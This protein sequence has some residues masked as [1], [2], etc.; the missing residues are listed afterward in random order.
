MIQA[1]P[2]TLAPLIVSVADRGGGAAIAARRLH[3]A[4]GEIGIQSRMAVR[5]HVP[6]D[7][8]V[9]PLLDGPGRARGLV[10]RRVARAVDH[11]ALSTPQTWSDG[12]LGT[13]SATHIDRL[14]PGV[15]NLH[16]VNDAMLSV[17][18]IG[19]VRAPIV[20][21]L[22]D[23]WAFT[24]GC[25]Y[26][27]ECGRYTQSCGHCP[28]LRAPGV[29]DLSAFN[30]A[31]KRRL[32]DCAR[33]TVVTPSRWMAGVAR[34]SALLGAAEVVAIPNPLN[35]TQFSPIERAAARAAL[36]VPADRPVVLFGAH[37][38][39]DRRK[40]GD[41]LADAIASQIRPLQ[42]MGA[43]VVVFG[44]DGSFATGLGLPVT[45]LGTLND[46]V[47]L[48]LAYSA[49]DLLALPSRQDN[50]PNMVAEAA[51]CEV[52]TVA[53]DVGGVGDM[54]IDQ[55][56]GALVVPF[57]VAAFGSAMVE[58]LRNP[59]RRRQ[60]GVASRHHVMRLCNPQDVAQQY[61]AV[62]EGARARAGR[63]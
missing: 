28:Q 17:L 40:G 24:G 34:N 14:N 16:W 54:V 63:Q 11:R 9:L 49:C 29:R 41:L 43:H 55:Q 30:H 7:P 61:R 1:E 50:L 3:E 32:W 10:A 53:F 39:A 20:W 46:T 15:V 26:D 25:H 48:R 36:G 59:N 4:L 33:F 21:T 57:D 42:Q 44:R 52:P 45:P 56:T 6:G 12:H 8:G 35:T 23:M 37:S 47:A 58:L 60:L 27:G 51:A 5:D 2:N 22:H 18:A 19:A 38:L 62:F 31:L 13:V